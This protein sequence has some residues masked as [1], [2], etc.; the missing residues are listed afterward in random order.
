MISMMMNC[1]RILFSIG[2]GSEK[3]G[4]LMHLDRSCYGTDGGVYK[5]TTIKLAQPVASDAFTR[6]PLYDE[7]TCEKFAGWGPSDSSP[8][9]SIVPRTRYQAIRYEQKRAGLL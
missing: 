6:E 7:D 5:I 9:V 1:G 2:H 8:P 3:P 4:D